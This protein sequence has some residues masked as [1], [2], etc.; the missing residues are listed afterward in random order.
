MAASFTTRPRC[1]TRA[2]KALPAGHRSDWLEA[3]LSV[4]R[5][6][7]F[8]AHNVT[9]NTLLSRATAPAD[10]EPPKSLT[11][12]FEFDFGLGYGVDLG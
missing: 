11:F 9:K 6:F 3:G 8:L 2:S 1:R 10:P 12:E 4:A 7:I 5:P